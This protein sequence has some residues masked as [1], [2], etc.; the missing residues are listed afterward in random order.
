M[1]TERLLDVAPHYVV[2]LALA[3]LIPAFVRAVV[4]DVG[5][6]PEV[7]LIFAI[8]FGYRRLVLWLDVAPES[9]QSGS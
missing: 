1:D 6:W 4:G 9:W 3:F 8:V 7:A 2:M 5:F